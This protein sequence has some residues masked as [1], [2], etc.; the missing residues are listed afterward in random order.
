MLEKDIAVWNQKT[1]VDKPLLVREDVN[2]AKY[3]RWFS[4]FYSERSKTYAE[5]C[6]NNVDF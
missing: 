3:R 5:A 4:Q 1:Y 2:I 6:E